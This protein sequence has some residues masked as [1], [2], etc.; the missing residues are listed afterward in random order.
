MTQETQTPEEGRKRISGANVF[1]ISAL[2]VLVC[3]AIFLFAA[4]RTKS[5]QNDVLTTQLNESNTRYTDLDKQY[6]AALAE[7][8]SYK[9][10]NA[11]LD[12]IIN[13]KEGQLKT[14]QASLTKEKK[15]RMLSDADYKKQLEQLGSIV[16]DLTSQ[17]ETLQKEKN[18]LIVRNDS[19]GKRVAEE[20]VLTEN[21][22][23]TNKVLTKKV[24]I[25]SLLIPQNIMAEAIKER[26]NGKETTTSRASKASEL[27]VCFDVGENK[28]A[29]AGSK[30][31]FARIVGPDGVTLA[32]QDKGSGV[33]QMADSASGEK[34]FTTKQ[35]IDYD[36]KPQ[37]V[38]MF[39]KQSTPFAAGH[40][41]AEIYQDGFFIGKKDFQLK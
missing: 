9:G 26:N 33:F 28:V 23:S 37:N 1:Y 35:S 30:T 14:F 10:Q 16:S 5:N 31:F 12:S 7:V 13:V 39:W 21:L 41:T 36:Q 2:V 29:D 11:T 4:N 22:S 32:V 18:V 27:R 34:A 25:A 40:Y 19:L 6:E 8:A 15:N 24:T 3:G 17:V 20:T 38:C